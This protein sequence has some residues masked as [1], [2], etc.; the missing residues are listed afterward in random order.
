MQAV[1]IGIIAAIIGLGIGYATWGAQSSQAQK[2]VAAAQAQ[3]AEARKAAERE[4]QLA[5]KVQAA[6]AKLKEAQESL[7]TETEQAKKL[8]GVLAKRKKK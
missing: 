6:E 5:T 1:V 7:K 3:L 2:D 8:E 4:G